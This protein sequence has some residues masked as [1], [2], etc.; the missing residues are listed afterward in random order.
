MRVVSAIAVAALASCATSS[1]A[2]RTELV[3]SVVS[4]S[5]DARGRLLR[6][7]AE[8]VRES[9]QRTSLDATAA[10]A[11][12][13]P[14]IGLVAIGVGPAELAVGLAPALRWPVTA[15]DG[16]PVALVSR[17]LEVH[18]SADE[19]VGWSFDEA[20]LELAVCGRTAAIPIRIFQVHVRDSERWTLVA[21]HLAYAP[22]MGTWL[23]AARG[24]EGGRIPDALERQPESAAARAALAE[25]FAPDGERA[26]WD[27]GPDALAVWPDA[28]QV[29]R[30]GAVAA[31]PTLA[32]ALDASLVDLDG[33]RLALGPSRA[34]AI[35]S[36]TL[37]ARTTQAGGEP[38][39]LRLRATVVIERTGD[40]GAATWRV[41]GAM[42]SVPVSARE[43][44]ARTL[45][46]IAAPPV[47]GNVTTSCR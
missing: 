16:Q 23:D 28:V 11:S 29:L 39:D 38:L 12:I 40:N 26:L 21:E 41:R 17:A 30:G 32:T 35:A 19:T 24:P 44:I 45:G 42:V 36:A 3:D 43:L 6:E 33:V 4:D 8:E 1:P 47:N 25:A 14:S 10:A 20:T 13:D 15:V 22:A 9:Y 2:R 5:G 34:V 37:G 27:A 7:L 31:G 18:L 46:V